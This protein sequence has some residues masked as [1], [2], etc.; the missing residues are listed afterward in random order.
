VC[1]CTDT[2]V[3]SCCAGTP[4]DWRYFLHE[5]EPVSEEAFAELAIE[6][7]SIPPQMFGE[8]E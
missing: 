7:R 2:F 4:F 5:P 1:A 3:C 8:S 6:P